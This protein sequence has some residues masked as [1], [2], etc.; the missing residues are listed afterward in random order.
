MPTLKSFCPAGLRSA[1]RGG[2]KNGARWPSISAVDKGHLYLIP[3]DLMQ[4]QSSR[5]LDGATYVCDFLDKSRD[6]KSIM[7]QT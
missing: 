5:I 4:R 1:L 2:E 6:E 7:P 3:P